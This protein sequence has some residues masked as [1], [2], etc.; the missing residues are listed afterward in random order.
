[1]A[2]SKTLTDSERTLR[3]RLA[4]HKRWSQEDPH[5]NAVRGQAGLLDRFRREIVAEQGDVVEPELTRRAEARRREHMT[6][7]AFNRSRARQAKAAADREA[8]AAADEPDVA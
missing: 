2:A 6:R 4:A 1:V 5:P 3:A 8:A 7:L